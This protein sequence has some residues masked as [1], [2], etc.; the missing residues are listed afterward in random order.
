[1]IRWIRHHDL[2]VAW[3]MLMIAASVVLAVL[4]R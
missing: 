2:L 1:M 4:V 3:I